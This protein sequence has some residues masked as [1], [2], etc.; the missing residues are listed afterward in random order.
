VGGAGAIGA[1]KTSA[2]T[3]AVRATGAADDGT[4]SGDAAAA[5]GAQQRFWQ[6][7]WQK[8]KQ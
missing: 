8:S 6:Q 2:G 4:V 5:A 3:T 1:T 7:R